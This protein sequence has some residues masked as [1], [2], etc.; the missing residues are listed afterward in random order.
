AATCSQVIFAASVILSVAKDPT[1]GRGRWWD[2]SS[3][4]FRMTRNSYRYFVGSGTDLARVGRRSRHDRAS[5]L[6]T[7][8]GSTRSL[9]RPVR[10]AVRDAGPAAQLPRVP[11]RTP[12]AARPEQDADGTRRGGA[13]C[14]SSC[15]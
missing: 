10:P 1:Y 3:I 5:S 11:P 8:T 15:G 6:S 13:H 4:L 12:V 2:S 7:G 14:G 9:R